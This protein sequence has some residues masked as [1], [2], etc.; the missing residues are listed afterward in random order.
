MRSMLRNRLKFQQ[1]IQGRP[2]VY[3]NAKKNGYQKF[4]HKLVRAL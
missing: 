3:E 1:D 2:I 4:D